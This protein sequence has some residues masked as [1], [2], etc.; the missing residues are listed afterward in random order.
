[1]DSS[2]RYYVHHQAIGIIWGLCQI[3]FVGGCATS[4]ALSD[5]G[6]NH[7]A[8]QEKI[9]QPRP[10]RSSLIHSFHLS[11]PPA[12]YFPYPFTAPYLLFPPGTKGSIAILPNCK[13][14]PH[15]MT[16]KARN[17]QSHCS[18]IVIHC[19]WQTWTQITNKQY[20][21]GVC[22]QLRTKIFLP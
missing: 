3:T 1:M 14:N 16:Q 4:I 6:S 2:L 11:S 10:G 7:T 22:R 20:S 15:R 9:L 12:L 8:G 5:L 13:I 18:L 17:S 21:T 19:F